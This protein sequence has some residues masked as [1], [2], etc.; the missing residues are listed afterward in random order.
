MSAIQ[1]QQQTPALAAQH[2]WMLQGHF[3]PEKFQGEQRKQYEQEAKRIERE[4][5]RKPF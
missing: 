4:W 2:D 3:S 5:D 1:Q